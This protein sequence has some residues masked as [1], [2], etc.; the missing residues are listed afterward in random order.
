MHPDERTLIGSC[1]RKNRY[2]TEEVARRIAARCEVQRGEVL[3]VYW[4]GL[5]LGY[6]L[7][8]EAAALPA[9]AAPP[10]EAPAKPRPRTRA[11]RRAEGRARAAEHNAAVQE[12]PREQRQ[13]EGLQNAAAFLRKNGWTV[14]PPGGSK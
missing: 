5:C 2:P 7:T 9:E 11:D 13:A 10:P 8:R 1:A 6:H 4:C 3:R 14:I 12:T